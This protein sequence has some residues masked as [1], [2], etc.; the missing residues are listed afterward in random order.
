MSP[1]EMR[2]T[3][4]LIDN[5]PAPGLF[6]QPA[7][8]QVEQ[9]TERT[10]LLTNKETETALPQVPDRNVHFRDIDR[11]RFWILFGTMIFGNTIA[12]FDSTLMAS[13]HPVITS[14]F[15]SSNSAS[16]LSTVFYLTSTVSQ[17][18]YG[19]VS[20]TIGRRPVY[21]FAETFFLFGTLWCALAGNI[22]SFI[23]A[24]AIC[25]IGAG[26][27]MSIS[28]IIT[29]DTVRIEFRG[30]YREPKTR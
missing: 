2:E 24:R 17:P 4:P 29:S 11:R 14:Y 28:N 9:V 22:G 1:P 15:K 27:V 13:A 19:R 6:V 5:A 23:A 21:L 20:D 18:L 16:W 12:F 10:A 26:G 3:R 30:I 8:G 7:A 25:G